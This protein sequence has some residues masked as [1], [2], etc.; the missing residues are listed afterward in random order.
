V[1]AGF[2]AVTT[3]CSGAPEEHDGPRIAF[4]FDGSWGD[5][6]EVTGPTLAGLRFAAL[7]SGDPDT[8]QPLNVRDEG[9][10]ELLREVA[11]DPAVVAVVVAPWTSPPAG[12]QEVLAA[13]RMPVVSLTW[14]WGP[15]AIDAPYLRL[16][17]DLTTEA[18]LLVAAG[19]PAAD[20]TVARCVAGDTHP[21]SEPL[22]LAVGRASARAGAS[23]RDA[24][25]VDPDQAA[26]AAAVA[27]RLARFG[28]RVVVWTGGADAL[29]LLVEAAPEVRTVVATSRTKTEGGIGVGVT[30]PARRLVTVC[31]CADIA[32]S[33]RPDLRR[34]VHDYQT[35]SGSAP[36][37]FAIE[38]FDVGRWVL[39]TAADG[40]AAVAARLDL[41][42]AI[43]GLLGTYRVDAEGSLLSGPTPP[44]AWRAFGSRWL[45]DAP[46]L[47]ALLAAS[48]V[49]RVPPRMRPDRAPIVHRPGREA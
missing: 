18:D 32:L 33:R 29:D 36:G 48:V 12:A 31:A 1:L 10:A 35:E 26:T 9:A 22:R 17:P 40:R 39:G 43:P 8:I 45:P 41:A 47:T 4:L 28:C 6:D 44:G 37:P 30:H 7:G 20:V 27:A 49:A 25:V 16:A 21:T 24:G 2:L 11:A 34:F 19:G 13:E 46:P 3:G 14:S 38:A 42:G 15:P 23:V 5:A